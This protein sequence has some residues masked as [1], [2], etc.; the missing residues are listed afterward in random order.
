MY[1]HKYEHKCMH[2]CTNAR[3]NICMHMWYVIDVIWLHARKSC[4]IH[5]VFSRRNQFDHIACLRRTN[6]FAASMWCLTAIL[7]LLVAF[8]TNIMWYSI[9]HK[10]CMTE[11]T[12]RTSN[13]DRLL[14][15]YKLTWSRKMIRERIC[16]APE[17]RLYLLEE[18]Y[19]FSWKPGIE[20]DLT[21]IL[22]AFSD[23]AFRV[24]PRTANFPVAAS[25]L[26]TEPPSAPVTSVTTMVC[27]CIISLGKFVWPPLGKRKK[28]T[29]S[30]GRSKDQKQK[31]FFTKHFKILLI[32]A[33]RHLKHLVWLP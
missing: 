4:F 13:R 19:D 5:V 10:H 26:A 20:A 11:G 8:T 33:I 9:R 32:W 16:H 7:S 29:S 22:S 1:V 15:D 14:A 6:K 27:F 18:E 2:A 21:F 12:L 24:S 17:A 30:K 25:A 28:R 31:K 23:F 3:V